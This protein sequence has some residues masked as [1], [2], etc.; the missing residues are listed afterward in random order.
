[1]LKERKIALQYIIQK[2]DKINTRQWCKMSSVKFDKQDYLMRLLNCKSFKLAYRMPLQLRKSKDFIENNLRY[3][4][5][6]LHIAYEDNHMEPLFCIWYALLCWPNAAADKVINCIHD[7]L[8]KAEKGEA[9]DKMVVNQMFN[10][11]EQNI[12]A[13]LIN[14]VRQENSK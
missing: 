13:Q 1:M 14:K 11:A 4:N 12:L 2:T 9:I 7:M 10:T 6:Y 3:G 5:H 8:M